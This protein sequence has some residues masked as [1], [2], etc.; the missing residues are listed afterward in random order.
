MNAPNN[1]KKPE[2]RATV[3]AR[4]TGTFRDGNAITNRMAWASANC[5]LI[6]PAPHA[7]ALPEGTGIA[8]SV[9]QVD[10]ANDTYDV[11]MGKRGLSK[12]VLQKLAAALGISWDDRASGRVDDCS[13]P[14]YC[15]WRAVGNYRAFDGQVQTLLAEKEL[16]LRVGSPTVEGLQAQQR[17]KNKSADNQVRE[18]R[19]HIQ[20]H[21]ET[22]A[23]LRAIR[24]LGIKT[25]YT[26]GELQKPFIAARIMFT[27][28]T[29]DPALRKMFAEKISD[30]F[31]NARQSLYAERPAPPRMSPPRGAAPARL[32]PGGDDNDGY[33][34]GDGVYQFGPPLA[35]PEPPTDA[36]GQAEDPD[37][38]KF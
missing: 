9:I 7:G 21:A 6:S 29:S 12:P 28:E 36:Q 31:L 23:Q 16:D 30:S 1:E 26:A 24:S 10:V 5:H 17:A 14:Y 22:K 37:K 20:A 25:A 2:D 35:E 8:L 11:G 34:D 19:M 27:G 3:L 38:G 18:M 15:R 13:D 32:G 4:V 33:I